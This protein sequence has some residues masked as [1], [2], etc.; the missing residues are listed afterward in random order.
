MPS[1][2]NAPQRVPQSIHEGHLVVCIGFDGAMSLDIAGP[3]QVF[4]TANEMRMRQGMRPWYRTQLAAGNDLVVTTSSGLRMLADVRWSELAPLPYNSTVLVPGGDGVDQVRHD[5]A[6]REWLVRT[7]PRVARMGSVCSGAL[8]LAGSGLLDG[9]CATTHWCRV[10]EMRQR[11]PDISVDSDRLHTFD[12][13]DPV[14]GHLFTSAGVTAG[15]D[16]ALALVEADLGRATALATA[17]QLVMFMRRPGG[18]AQF[19]PL[20]TPETTHAPRLAQLLDWIPGQIGSDLSVERLAEQACLPPRTLARVFHKELGTTPAKYVERVRVE[21]A[22]ALLGQRQAS[23][24]TV[25]R[26]CG[27]GHPENLRR[28]FHRHLAVSPQAFAERFGSG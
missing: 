6:L 13:D 16:L 5:T 12:A 18:Q 9:H 28:S 27:F 14:Y 21:A 8:V 26:L 20:L 3:L 23:V 25:A 2:P 19:S 1:K 15:I 17:R 7:E 4:S 10:D 24:A 22:S 11:H